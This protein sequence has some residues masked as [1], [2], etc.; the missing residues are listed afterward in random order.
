[1]AL[2]LSARLRAAMSTRSVRVR[3]F[4]RARA[5]GDVDTEDRFF[6]HLRLRNGVFKTTGTARMEETVPFLVA[7][8]REA[9][10]D[11]TEPLRVLDVGCSSGVSTVALHRALVAAGLAVETT[12]TDLFTRARF[13]ERDDGCGMLFDPNERVIQ[14]D[15]AD[16]AASWAWPPRRAD[17]VF[18]PRKLAR[19][20]A[21]QHLAAGAFRAALYRPRDRMSVTDVPLTSSRVDR[22][23]GV[24]V[25]EEDLARP[26]VPGRFGF[27]RAANILNPGYFDGATITRFA[28][29]LFARLDD[30]ALFFVVRSIDGQ[31]RGTLFRRARDRLEVVTEMNGGSEVAHHILAAPSSVTPRAPQGAMPSP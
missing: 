25:V 22:T 13:V 20:K 12:G 10:G 16:W 3:D 2:S 19:A 18:R 28:A 29:S 26:V 1:M 11:D 9:R 15:L 4:L 14:V 6:D 21:L 7:H 27:V 8:L 17:V 30:G 23:P 31:N 5:A 24:S